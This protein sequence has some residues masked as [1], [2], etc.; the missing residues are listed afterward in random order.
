MNEVSKTS[1]IIFDDYRNILVVQ[2]QKGKKNQPEL[3]SFIER[4]IKG[5]ETPEKCITKAVEHDLN[6]IIFNLE[7]VKEYDGANESSNMIVF[8]G[9]L[10]G[11]I[12]LHKSLYELRWINERELE[13]YTFS[14][15]EKE[16]ISDFFK[17]IDSK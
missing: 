9:N 17:R 11:R 7:I 14:S 2:K 16:I 15:N 10:K 8:S 1:I 4:E 3:W 6:N 5:K 13:L 12:L